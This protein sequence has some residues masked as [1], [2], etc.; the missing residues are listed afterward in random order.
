MNEYQQQRLYEIIA[1]FRADNTM[2]N[3]DFMF[4][5]QSLRDAWACLKTAEVAV[6][7]GYAHAVEMENLKR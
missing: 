5:L 1:Q 6:A 2:S 4:I 7:T 3:R